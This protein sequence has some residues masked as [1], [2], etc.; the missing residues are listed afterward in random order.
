M[1]K[2]KF[3]FW[4]KIDEYFDLKTTQVLF[5]LEIDQTNDFKFYEKLPK[6]DSH[7]EFLIIDQF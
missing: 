6:F 1:K 5:S 4:R 7:R 3:R 2:I